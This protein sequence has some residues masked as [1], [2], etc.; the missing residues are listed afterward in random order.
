L[1]WSSTNSLVFPNSP[2]YPTP[3]SSQWSL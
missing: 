3:Q 1:E 2:A